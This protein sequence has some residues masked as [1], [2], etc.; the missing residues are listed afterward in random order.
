MQ[1]K[2]AWATRHADLFSLTY[3]D[4]RGA[5]EMGRAVSMPV[6]KQMI[7]GEHKVARKERRVGL[8]IKGVD[9][10]LGSPS[11]KRTSQCASP[12]SSS[13]SASSSK[14]R[15]LPSRP[16]LPAHWMV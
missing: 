2:E 3:S 14:S 12:A 4:S 5:G 1:D 13:I 6:P 7:S 10:G 11:S 15:K 8:G 9:M 16:R